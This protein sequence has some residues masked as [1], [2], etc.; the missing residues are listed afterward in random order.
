[1]FAYVNMPPTDVPLGVTKRNESQVKEWGLT[2]RREA[3]L[4]ADCRFV[5]VRIASLCG[6]SLEALV[7][8][9]D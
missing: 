9:W 2:P 8:V 4:A 1:M 6:A 7:R 5:F 3:A